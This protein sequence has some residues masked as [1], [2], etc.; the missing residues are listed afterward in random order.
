MTPHL[1]PGLEREKLMISPIHA[2]LTGAFSL[3]LAVPLP[4][5]PTDNL[6]LLVRDRG[7]HRAVSAAVRLYGSE[8]RELLG[9]ERGRVQDTL[10][11]GEYGV[12]V[13]APGYHTLRTYI[14]VMAPA[15]VP[16]TIMLDG[17]SPAEEQLPERREVKFGVGQTLVD[18]YIVAAEDGKP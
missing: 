11:A 18:G 16:A 4:C 13:S 6:N 10:P 9:D 17:L 2:F 3:I 7:T 1:A 8:A 12:E 14:T 5:A 15:K